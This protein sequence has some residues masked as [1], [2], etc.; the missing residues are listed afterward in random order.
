MSNGYDSITDFV[1]SRDKY[2]QPVTLNYQGEEKFKSLPGGCFTI[3]MLAAM[4]CY[5]LLKGKYMI[6][7]ENWNLI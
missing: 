2:G 7:N 1:R 5:I 6:D 4:L 3:L